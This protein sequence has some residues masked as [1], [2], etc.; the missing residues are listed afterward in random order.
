[1]ESYKRLLFLPPATVTVENYHA[2]LKERAERA[3]RMARSEVARPLQ[4]TVR[5]L[6]IMVSIHSAGEI[7][8]PF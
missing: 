5:V 1:M 4:E 8:Q 7:F 6:R 3:V 2:S